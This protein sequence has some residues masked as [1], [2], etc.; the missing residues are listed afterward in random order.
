VTGQ[1]AL[2]K[3]YAPTLDP[4]GIHDLIISTGVNINSRNPQFI[5]LLG[6]GLA[7][8]LGTLMELGAIA[9][10][11][12]TNPGDINNNG[13]A[14]EF[15]EMLLLMDAIRYGDTTYLGSCIGNAD[16]DGNCTIDFNDLTLM[17]NIIIG[18]TVLYP[19]CGSCQSYT[20][21]PGTP[22]GACCTLPGDINSNGLP[23]E[24]A[25]SILL[26]NALATGDTNYLA[27]CIGNADLNGDCLI[28]VS[29][30]ELMRNVILLII[31]D[32]LPARH[33]LS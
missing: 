18:D 30:L 7:N 20:F 9:G 26:Y 10:D 32:A 13:I 11:C 2:M 21:V 33:T 29:D 25:D 19:T 23:F 1:I 22:T 6:G 28:N 17:N 15:S 27:P 24:V 14:F 5:G 12:C 31:W 4:G 16:I 8:P 3:Q